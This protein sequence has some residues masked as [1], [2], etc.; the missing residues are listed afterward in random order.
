MPRRAVSLTVTLGRLRD[1]VG[2]R[3]LNCEIVQSGLGDQFRGR[4][5]FS[6]R[7]SHQTSGCRITQPL[8]ASSSAA[9]EIS[10]GSLLAGPIS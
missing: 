8:S 7:A 3:L 6:F 9:N 5:A 1:L 2:N 10:S 4:R